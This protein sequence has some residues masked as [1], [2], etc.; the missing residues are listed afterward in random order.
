[1]TRGGA[2]NAL[3]C[4]YERM[5]ASGQQT[6]MS[7]TM[8]EKILRL[9]R[10]EDALETLLTSKPE[11]KRERNLNACSSCLENVIF[12]RLKQKIR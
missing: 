8:F 5:H 9:K 3:K 10:L 7:E 12:K 11:I 4:H 2:T 1:M 6:S